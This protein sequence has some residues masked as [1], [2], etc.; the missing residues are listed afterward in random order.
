[1]YFLDSGHVY[2]HQGAQ[3]RWLE[4]TMKANKH[5]EHQVA[6]YHVPLYPS[7][8]SYNGALSLAGRLAWGPLFDKY[9]SFSGVFP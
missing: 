5:L 6:I 1:M 3:S 8:R 2:S 9:I 7:H 4:R